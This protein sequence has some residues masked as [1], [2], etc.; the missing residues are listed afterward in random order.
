MRYRVDMLWSSAYLS[1]PRHARMQMWHVRGCIQPLWGLA[2]AVLHTRTRRAQRARGRERLSLCA[3]SE[4]HA[5]CLTH[6]IVHRTNWCAP[7]SV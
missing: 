1:S 2:I 7:A 5:L 3:R 4:W 6:T